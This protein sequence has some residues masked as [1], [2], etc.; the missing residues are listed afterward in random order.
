[1]VSLRQRLD[2]RVNM[3]LPIN[4][5]VRRKS[6]R[7][8][9]MTL[10]EVVL[11]IV[12]LTT[13]L[14]SMAVFVGRF[15]KATRLM[16]TRNTASE[17]VADRIEDVKGAVR[18]SSMESDYNGTESTISGYP[19]YVRATTIKHIG[20]DG[21]DVDDYKVVTVVVTSAQLASPS[22]KSTII[23]AF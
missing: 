3:K 11:A 22:K 8:S 13:S 15:A 6:A 4:M 9:G 10:V 17:L 18:Y 20:G 16:N 5:K 23:S 19:G 7:R 12:M 21:P 14:L 1:M 2:A